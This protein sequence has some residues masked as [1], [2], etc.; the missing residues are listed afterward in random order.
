MTVGVDAVQLCV[1]IAETAIASHLVIAARMS[2]LGAGLA[3]GG[4]IPFAEFSRL[5]PEK[6]AA[7]SKA[8]IGVARSLTVK[9]GPPARTLSGALVKDSLAML[10]WWERS[11]HVASAWWSPV[12]KQAAANAQR[13]YRSKGP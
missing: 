12:H 11:I 5:I 4:K 10:N 9:K 2:M 6:A 8:H 13:L 7:L 1:Q 3:D